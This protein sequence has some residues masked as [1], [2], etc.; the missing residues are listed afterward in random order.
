VG[1]DSLAKVA[2]APQLYTPGASWDASWPPHRTHG[3]RSPAFLA[4]MPLAPKY[5]ARGPRGRDSVGSARAR[6]V[7]IARNGG[8]GGIG[9]EFPA[10]IGDGLETRIRGRVLAAAG[11]PSATISALLA[12]SPPVQ[13]YS[14][15]GRPRC[16]NTRGLGSSGAEILVVWA[17]W[18]HSCGMIRDPGEANAAWRRSGE[19]RQ[20]RALLIAKSGAAPSPVHEKRDFSPKSCR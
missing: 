9:F 16:G 12:K 10:Y 18:V 8:H 20:L 1:D 3:R 17:T 14:A 2:I 7:D 5:S 4:E 19:S 15:R 11:R 13:K 6:V